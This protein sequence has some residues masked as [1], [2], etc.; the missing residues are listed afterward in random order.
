MA[1]PQ[2]EINQTR[3][4][5]V[6][7]EF[8]FPEDYNQDSAAEEIVD[9]LESVGLP[10]SWM[11]YT[12][13]VT[14]KWKLVTDGSVY[15][16]DNEYYGFELVSPV[17]TW[18]RIGEVELALQTLAEIGAVVNNRCG[19]HVHHDVRDYQMMDFVRIYEL[20]ASCED[21][22]DNCVH[23]T[24]RGNRNTFC[25]TIKRLDIPKM[26]KQVQ[27]F[28]EEYSGST[29]PPV[30]DDA[31][32]II[33]NRISGDYNTDSL[34]YLKLN[35]QSFRSYGTIEFRHFHGTLDPVAVKSWI[36]LT[37]RI[38]ET[39]KTQTRFHTK[40]KS[41]IDATF[42]LRFLK[43]GAIPEIAEAR[44]YFDAL[45]KDGEEA[46]TRGWGEEAVFQT[47]FN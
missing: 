2:A 42:L 26:R 33:L 31:V 37:Q 47:S 35:V 34:R 21:E 5:G 17:L 13:L 22:L 3:T 9:A 15:D 29:Y 12:H 27:T 10:A 32:G 40:Q 8:L 14:R 11:Q 4:F 7:I 46:R 20:Y 39:A 16:D 24:R 25:K 1:R 6:E 36:L 18:D 38:V 41:W 19:I 30:P 44:K 43:R 28:E 23:P 45:R